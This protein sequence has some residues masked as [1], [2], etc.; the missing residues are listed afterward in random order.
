MIFVTSKV[1]VAEYV[2]KSCTTTASVGSFDSAF[3]S[4][5]RT[6]NWPCTRSVF[7]K[8]LYFWRNSKGSLCSSFRLFSVSCRMAI[9]GQRSSNPGVFHALNTLKSPS[10]SQGE[11]A[12]FPSSNR[13]G[14]GCNRIKNAV[15][16]APIRIRLMDVPP[17]KQ[18][19]VGFGAMFVRLAELKVKL[20]LL[21]PACH[22]AIAEKD[23]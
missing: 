2:P 4:V 3:G 11:S 19:Q 12:F 21:R 18:R 8:I 1:Q 7:S 6:T 23:R 14:G 22:P 16:I 10:C 17:S 15:K 13:A 9:S 20:V 5:R